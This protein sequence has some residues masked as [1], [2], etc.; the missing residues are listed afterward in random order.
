MEC[1]STLIGLQLKCNA[2]QLKC[3]AL[4]LK[5]KSTLN[6]H[7]KRRELPRPREESFHFRTAHKASPQSIDLNYP[8]LHGRLVNPLD[9]PQGK[10]MRDAQIPLD[11]SA[12]AVAELDRQLALRPP[13]DLAVMETR[14]EAAA[15]G[16][17]CL[18]ELNDLKEQEVM[19]VRT[20][21][22]LQAVMAIGAGALSTVRV[23]SG[24]PIGAGVNFVAGFAAKVGS[25]FP[26]QNRA[27][28]VACRS[29]KPMLH[30]QLGII[31]RSVLQ[32]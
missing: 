13:P 27:L 1:K 15:F 18:D 4:Q 6:S 19:E 8:L 17:A 5:C 7:S 29:V 21:E 31:A 32:G 12:S 9:M 28:R 10:S 23:G 30:V 3:N 20:T 26:P 14:L 22:A 11:T 24:V 2:L 16:R 25:C